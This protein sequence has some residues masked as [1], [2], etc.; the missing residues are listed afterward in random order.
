MKENNIK[1]KKAIPL[2][3]GSL[4]TSDFLSRRVLLRKYLQT[5]G[6]SEEM[7][8]KIY[9]ASSLFIGVRG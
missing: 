4:G 6:E 8:K 7:V 1:A 9:G 3:R 5:F 2:N